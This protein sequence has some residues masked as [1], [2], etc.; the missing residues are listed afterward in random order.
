MQLRVA[1]FY[2]KFEPVEAERILRQLLK[3]HKDSHGARRMLAL[4]LA[5]QGE[6]GMEEAQQL[7][8]QAGAEGAVA[9]DDQRI[10][11]LLLTQQGGVANLERAVQIL[12][13]LVSNQTSP[14]LGD[15]QL[16]AQLYERQSQVM[17]D[18]A[19]ITA[20]LS[21]AQTQWEQAATTAG[22][23]PASLAAVVQFFSRHK[24]TAEA[25]PWL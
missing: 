14:A 21:A 11:A 16:L 22:A 10:R 18:L 24:R 17:D 12:E 19:Q 20:K 1:Q 7:L 13:G 5:S 6:K 3:D 15:R 4:A 23:P 9:S 25:L 2:L 8:T